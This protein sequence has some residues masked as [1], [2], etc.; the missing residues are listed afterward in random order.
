M[1]TFFHFKAN[2]FILFQACLVFFG[3][4]LIFYHIFLFKI[5]LVIFHGTYLISSSRG[6]EGLIQLLIV[7][8]ASHSWRHVSLCFVKN[9]ELILSKALSTLIPCG[10]S[11]G[12]GFLDKIAICFYRGNHWEGT[13]FYVHFTGYILLDNKRS[14]YMNHKFYWEQ[15]QGL[16][17]SG[18]IPGEQ[19]GYL[20]GSG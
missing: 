17:F 16:N 8:A 20:P 3:S 15:N 13:T 4:T 11:W 6:Y 2:Q 7:L 10:L 9:G 1:T 12:C 5:C 18:W 14:T 19:R